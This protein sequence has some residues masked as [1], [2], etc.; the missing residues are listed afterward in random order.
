MT[1][2]QKINVSMFTTVLVL[3]YAMMFVV[4]AGRLGA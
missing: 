2:K 3:A 1:T 4:E